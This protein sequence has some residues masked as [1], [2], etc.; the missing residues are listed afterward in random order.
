MKTHL[1]SVLPFAVIA[2]AC[3]ALC[4]GAFIHASSASEASPAP[5]ANKKENPD[6]MASPTPT[7]KR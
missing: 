7:P 3:G 2:L 5:D 6:A 4:L 1:K